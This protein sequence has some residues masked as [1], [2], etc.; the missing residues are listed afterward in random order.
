VKNYKTVTFT[1]NLKYKPFST[2]HSVRT[3]DALIPPVEA[4]VSTCR[5]MNSNRPDFVTFNFDKKST[6]FMIPIKGFQYGSTMAV[7][8]YI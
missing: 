7:L 8:Y 3:T 1:V 2:S 4:I 5:P 6:N